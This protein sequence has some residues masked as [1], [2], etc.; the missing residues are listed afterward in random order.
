MVF[1]APRTMPSLPLPLPPSQ[2]KPMTVEPVE[3][4][5]LVFVRNANGGE[6]RAGREKPFTLDS[7]S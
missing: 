2:G 6:Y 1:I 4:A 7:P 5:A 3:C